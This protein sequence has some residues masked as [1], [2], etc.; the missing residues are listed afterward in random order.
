M[1]ETVLVTIG[2]IVVLGVGAQWLATLLRIPSIVLLLL[3]GMLVG[4]GL[5]WVDPRAAFGDALFPTVTVAVGILLFDGGLGLKFRALPHGSARVILRLTLIGAGI[6]TIVGGALAIPLFHVSR[7]IGILI[8]AIVV[9]SGPTVVGPLLRLSRPRDPAATI[10]RWEGIAIDP[11]GATIG[12]SVLSVVLHESSS[13]IADLLATAAVGIAI[14]LV[15]AGLLTASLRSYLIPDD[16]EVAV[17]ILFAVGALVLA[18]S[19]RSEAGLF[20]ATATGVAMANQ[21]F[22]PVEGIRVF[23]HTLGP[24]ILGSLFITLGAMIVPGLLLDSAGSIALFVAAL[25]L[26]VRPLVAYVSTL[27]LHVPARHRVLIG[28]MA[29]RGIVAAATAALYGDALTA[30]GLH[31][32][33]VETA[34]Y[35]TILGTVVIY[36]L[37]TPPLV[38][39]LKIAR[40]PARGILLFG[41]E[42][43]MRELARELAACD[44]PVLLVGRPWRDD[45]DTPVEVHAGSLSELRDRADLDRFSHA[46]VLESDVDRSRVAAQMS[47]E[48]LGRGQVFRLPPVEV[49]Q[50]LDPDGLPRPEALA[51]APFGARAQRQ[52]IAGMI[53]QGATVETITGSQPPSRGAPHIPLIR[54]DAGGRFHV[55]P[56]DRPLEMGDRLIV[57]RP[58]AAPPIDPSARA[59]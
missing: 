37:L 24:L 55:N 42:A 48:I 4:P 41:D 28:A 32:P 29:P 10:L 16:L 5:G 57:L 2:L 23:G 15:A 38:R 44:V 31:D 54:V 8:G 30:N 25:V 7:G 36:G 3:C 9:V 20:A 6:T 53:E 18:E 43:W 59:D 13:P 47:A 22:V 45:P 33:I 21:R 14:G 35:G 56:P 19:L 27:A 40:P 58:G 12:I 39:G 17:G 51:R 50:E 34:V 11:I 49:A 26:L 52:A 1:S 46:I